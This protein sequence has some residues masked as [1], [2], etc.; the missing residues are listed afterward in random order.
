MRFLVLQHDASNKTSTRRAR[1]EPDPILLRP[2]GP[3]GFLEDA[4][5]LLLRCLTNIEQVDRHLPQVEEDLRTDRT[6]VLIVVL[7]LG[8]DV[9]L[10]QPVAEEIA[11]LLVGATSIEAWRVRSQDLAALLR[12]SP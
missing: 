1:L 12:G 4:V 7:C 8:G 9:L 11:M 5:W 6:V 10:T 3:F 2:G